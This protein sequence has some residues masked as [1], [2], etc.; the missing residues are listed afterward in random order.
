MGPLRPV[1]HLRPAPR[2]LLRTLLPL[3]LGV[4]L[5]GAWTDS[6]QGLPLL[7]F[8]PTREI[9][10]SSDAAGYFVYQDDRSRIFLG[11]GNVLTYD[12]AAWRSHSLNTGYNI[13]AMAPGTNHRLWIGGFEE[14]GYL[15][16]SPRGDFAFTSLRGLLPKEEQVLGTVWGCEQ[17]GR[18]TYFVCSDKLLCWDG[19]RFTVTHFATKARLFPVR[20]GRELW[21]THAETGLYCIS[22]QEVKLA[23]PA[24]SL[25][26]SAAFHLFR[27]NGE[28]RLISNDGIVA[29]GRPGTPL[30][31][32][33]FSQFGLTN[34]ITSVAAAP[35][36]TY[37]VASAHGG[38][39]IVSSAGE[40]LRILDTR[41]GLPSNCVLAV[42]L[43]REG[44]LWGV[45]NSGPFRIEAP[46]KITVFNEQS[47][48]SKGAIKALSP[49]ANSLVGLSDSGVFRLESGSGKLARF[50]KIP[51]LEKNYGVLTPL[52]NG[53]L[54]GRFG[55][56]D[57]Y[58][59]AQSSA[60]YELPAKSFWGLSPLQLDPDSV[61]FS[62]EKNLLRLTRLPSGKW[63]THELTALPDYSSRSWQDAE[64]K[65][66]VNST[67]SG[68]HFLDPT[69]G[70][71]ARLDDG[72][73]A[74]QTANYLA[75]AGQGDRLYFARN[76][77][78]FVVDPLTRRATPL[79][80]VPLART[81][82]HLQPS[83]DGKRLYACFERTRKG[84][85][86]STVG[87]G[88]F[89][90]ASAGA[91]KP[92][93]E[94]QIARL[95]AIG[96]PNTLLLLSEH[97]G[98]TLWIGGSEAAMRLR[99]DDL[100]VLRPPAR[101]RLS[102]LRDRPAPESDAAPATF[103]FAGHKVSL[104]IDTPEILTRR[105]LLFQT[106][107]GDE[108]TPWSAPTERS[109]FEF[110]NLSEG[111]YAFSV[112]SVNPA[113]M[114]SEPAELRFRILPPWYRTGWAY[115]GYAGV[116]VAAMLGYMRF[117]ERRVRE[118]NRHLERVVAERTA[119]LVK[120]NAA[121]DEF[122]A[123]ISH[124]IRNP[125]NGV[126]GLASAIDTAPLDEHSKQRFA[127]LRHCAT[128]LSSLLDDI[129][130]FSKLQA[131]AVS[132]DPQPFNLPELVQSIAAI[133]AV[134][135]KQA[136]I[137]VE[138]AISPAVPSLL[139]GDAARIRQIL[140]N[141]VI[142]ALKYAGR[143]TVCLT[144][145][146]RQSV[147]DSCEVTFAVSDDGPGISPEEQA[148][149]FSRFERGAAA[150]QNR[151]AGAGLGLA[152]CSTLADKMGGRLWVESEPGQGAAFHFSVRLPVA[153]DATLSLRPAAPTLPPPV[154]R[155]L[156]VDDEEYNRIALA[157]MLAELG[158]ASVTAGESEAALAAARSQKFDA[159]FLD[160]DLPGKNGLEIARELR[161]LPGFPADL[162]VVATTAFGT[163]EKRAQCLAAGMN[164]FLSKPV[165]LEKIRSALGAATALSRPAAPLQAPGEAAADPLAALKLIAS[166]KGVALGEELDLYLRELELENTALAAA[167]EQRDRPAAAR[168]A[169]RLTGRLGFVHADAAE[170]CAREIEAAATNE[171]WEQAD[172]DWRHYQATLEPLR[173]RLRAAGS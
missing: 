133:T 24:S 19:Q 22:E 51:G 146:S 34:R 90:L 1:P 77:R 154:Y 59:G 136:G 56:I 63:L 138:V 40:L 11:G 55:A 50:V 37:Y 7:E 93:V 47:G 118:R 108:A 95:D 39:A 61:T 119:E 167:L 10:A 78:G 134:E 172:A 75:F 36:G 79:G 156:V 168:A 88:Y 107:L 64:G 165:S 166:R 111:S 52:A 49:F 98:D 122:L 82:N 140:L 142:N 125:M 81:L 131:G 27:A 145:W 141:F 8:F 92:W 116:L 162:P 58:D 86:P 157:A 54:L 66:W 169:H 76:N 44:C 114:L 28:L 2:L 43:D 13:I 5:H 115:G 72:A 89:D 60:V 129:L 104:R 69:T 143:G 158:F 100:P 102:L 117:R 26:S 68:I 137:P 48:L 149:I 62:Y 23:Y 127:Y 121:K 97:G 38:I 70:K 20:L 74:N 99:P 112:R 18:K 124:E 170:A 65:L 14:L 151:V 15:T 25:P 101:P 132:L 32:P 6:A 148:K 103:P 113:G 160:F 94:L 152:L 139:V 57:F 128:H 155:A 123:G 153:A 17:V 91:E 126:V 105:A 159:V 161:A 30:C 67:Q 16:E 9:G 53:L 120:A 4:G 21:F 150:R 71:I 147:P 31:S 171:I 29:V 33:A 110:T 35:D 85:G 42:L 109:S 135:S 46:G 41:D 3:C 45:T 12:G 144:V 173:A 84:G 96:T 130:D 106:R 80:D 73:P 164:A 83:P 163:P 87:V